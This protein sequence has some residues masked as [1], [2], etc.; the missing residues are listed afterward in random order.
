MIPVFKIPGTL[1][2]TSDDCNKVKSVEYCQ[3]C[4]RVEARFYHC[5]NWNC[6]DCYF[7]TATKA[8]RAVEDRLTGVQRAY[9]GVGKHPGKLTHVTFSL[10]ESDYED[11]DIWKERQNVY[12]HAEM[13]GLTGGV[14]IFH[15]FR[16]KSEYKKPLYD[17]VKAAGLI[18]GLWAGIHANAL[19]K[20]SWDEYTYFAPHFHVIGYFP[21]I[22]MKSNVFHERTGWVYKSIGYNKERNVFKT[23]RYLFT[24]CAVIEGKQ[25]CTYFGVASY[26]KTTVEIIKEKTFKKCPNCGS[27]NYYLIECGDYRYDRFLQGLKPAADEFVVHVRDTRS[28]RWYSVKTKDS[29]LT[30]FCGVTA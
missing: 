12:K 18:G 22:A 24:H 27:E 14:V 21:Q 20:A 2:K 15:P 17:A 25:A 13:I 3:D 7:W 11:F 29:V 28:V 1:G 6:P 9:N 5:N 26:N 8:A 23:A 30:S 4:N 16:V 19:N 10:P